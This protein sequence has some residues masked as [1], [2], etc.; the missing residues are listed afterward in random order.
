MLLFVNLNM[1]SNEIFVSRKGRK[2]SKV[3]KEELVFA[4]ARFTSFAGF[5]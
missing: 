5:A 4:F 1:F 2:G 3:R